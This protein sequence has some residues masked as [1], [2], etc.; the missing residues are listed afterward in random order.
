MN[1]PASEPA[2]TTPAPAT[3]RISPAPGD[4]DR[5]QRIRH[6]T[7]RFPRLVGDFLLL[8]R[9]RWLTLAA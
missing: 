5:S 3:S 4:A 9:R 6:A 1:E 7:P 8:D 2:D